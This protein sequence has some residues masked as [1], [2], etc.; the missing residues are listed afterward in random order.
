MQKSPQ[1]FL[2][3]IDIGLGKGIGYRAIMQIMGST[4]HNL[5]PNISVEEDSVVWIP[6][7]NGMYS[8]KTAREAL[9]LL[10]FGSS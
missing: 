4:P 8:V 3:G 7:S 9:R 1:S 10:W 5:R 2:M 6:A